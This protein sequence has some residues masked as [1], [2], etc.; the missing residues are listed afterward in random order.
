MGEYVIDPP[1]GP[2]HRRDFLDEES[3][4]VLEAVPARGAAT[5]EELTARSGLALRTVLRR[6]SLLELA[7]LVERRADGYALLRRRAATW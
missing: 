4:L 1:R 2:A 7:G 6:L 3:A 5:P